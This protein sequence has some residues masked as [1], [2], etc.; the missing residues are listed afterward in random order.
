MPDWCRSCAAEITW[1]VTINGARAPIDVKPVGA[2]NI[3]LLASERGDKP[4]LA[5]VIS[6]LSDKAR[7]AA[8][9]ADVPL[10]LDHHATCP[11]AAGWRQ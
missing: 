7:E 4:P 1:A 5:L 6:N 3:V 8:V 11:D 9:R 2:G 10:Y